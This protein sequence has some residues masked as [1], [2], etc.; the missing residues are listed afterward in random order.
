MWSLFINTVI[1]RYKGKRDKLSLAEYFRDVTIGQAE[2][3]LFTRL[4]I[5]PVIKDSIVSRYTTTTSWYDII[6]SEIERYN[7]IRG[8]GK[9]A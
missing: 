8:S 1:T 6:N 3:P 5:M 9:L 2:E 7:I 4:F